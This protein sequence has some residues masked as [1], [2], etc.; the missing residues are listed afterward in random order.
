MSLKILMI[1]F[2]ILMIL[3]LSI[4]FIKPDWSLV[5]E[6]RAVHATKLTQQQN[7]QMLLD[8]IS[9]LASSVESQKEAEKF[10]EHYVPKDMDQD[11][12]IDMLNFLAGQSGVVADGITLE[13]VEK[14]EAIDES[15]LVD[16]MG[17]PIIPPYAVKTSSY[18][19]EIAVRGH[20]ENIKEF[21]GRVAHMNRLHKTRAFAIGKEESNE[22][23]SDPGILK[24]T[25]QAEFD[26]L[27]PRPVESA[28]NVPVFARG[29]FDTN[30][31]AAVSTWVTNTVP[32]LEKPGT[33]RANPFQ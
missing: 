13:K 29:T 6:K 9:A 27:T 24:G 33:G 26:Y 12:V 2:S 19:A 22:E 14:E 7:A 15:L 11:R 5:Q 16:E 23:S 25:F 3:V 28:L 30:P 21:F 17:L 20:Y 4:G 32:L 8:N 18:K 31:L 1:P 10:L